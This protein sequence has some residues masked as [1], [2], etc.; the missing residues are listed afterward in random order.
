MVAQPQ[1]GTMA[2]LSSMTVLILMIV[3]L[4]GLGHWVYRNR[5]DTTEQWTAEDFRGYNW[6]FIWFAMVGVN[7]AAW[8]IVAA[9][10]D[11]STG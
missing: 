8:L 3:A 10:V 2:I 5:L 1:D 9:M 6:G 7:V 11:Q 4:W